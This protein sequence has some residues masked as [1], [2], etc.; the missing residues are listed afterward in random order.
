MQHPDDVQ[1]FERLRAIGF[2]IAKANNIRCLVIEPKRRAGGAY[3][4]AYLSECRISIEVRGK[5]L[6]RDGGEWAK[7]RYRHACNL[8]TLAHELAHLQEHQTH[9][10]TG[11]GPRFRTYETSLLA[12][13]MQLDATSPH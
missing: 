11:H 7:N 3:G 4:L 8:H 5:E 12:A 1:Y 2:E 13:V 10:K 9:G 6:M